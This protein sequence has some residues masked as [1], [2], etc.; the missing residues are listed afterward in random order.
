MLA[1]ENIQAQPG[2]AALFSITRYEGE[3]PHGYGVSDFTTAHLL[4]SQDS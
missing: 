3:Q 1:M 2:G 4:Y